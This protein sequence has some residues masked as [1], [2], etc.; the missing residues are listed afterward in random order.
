MPRV[1]QRRCSW[2]GCPVLVDGG[3][4]PAHRTRRVRPSPESRGYD[5]AHRAQPIG[6]SCERCGSTRN[7]TRGHI[8]AAADGGTN[9]PSNYLCLCQSC[10]N[11]Q[12]A[13]DTRRRHGG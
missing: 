5:G 10:Q 6:E 1:P 4:C 9:D 8:I 12:A 2:P 7:L 3:R 11:R 13:Q